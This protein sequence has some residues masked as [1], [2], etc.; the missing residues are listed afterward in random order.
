MEF[1]RVRD[2]DD[3]EYLAETTTDEDGTW[4]YFA[5]IDGLVAVGVTNDDGAV[6]LME[7]AHGWRLPYGP[8]EEGEDP[9][10]VARRI[11]GTLTGVEVEDADF[12]RVTEFTREHATTGE[13]TTSF[14]AVVRVAPV[15]GEP[16]AGNPDFEPW[17]D[18]VVGWF[19]E[20]PDEA[21]H[22]HG[23]AVSDVERF[24]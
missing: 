22:E 16:T 24:L 2:R 1:E 10:A 18:L 4:A 9:L 14:D 8:V 5:G 17:E 6:L 7:S 20:V 23:S 3:V 15:A 19:A 11:A 12:E 13:T 21:Y